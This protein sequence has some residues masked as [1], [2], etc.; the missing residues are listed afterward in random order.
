MPSFLDD[1]TSELCFDKEVFFNRDFS[2][3]EFVCERRKVVGLDQLRDDLRSH[4]KYLQACLVELIN[5]DYTD[6]V[7]L[8]SNLVG[9]E[10]YIGNISLPLNKLRD[11]VSEINNIIDGV[12]SETAK[13]LAERQKDRQLRGQILLAMEVH[14]GVQ[15]L[16]QEK[17]QI[18]TPD[19]VE[20]TANQIH[21][22]MISLDRCRNVA[23]AR[24]SEEVIDQIKFK[25]QS[26]LEA[27]FLEGL[28]AHDE[29]ILTHVLAVGVAIERVDYLEKFYSDRIVKSALEEIVTER[30]LREVLSEG[31]FNQVVMFVTTNCALLSKSA[32][33]EYN[34]ILNSV[35]PVFVSLAE[36]RVPTLFSLTSATMFHVRYNE[37]QR[38]LETLQHHMSEKS[39]LAFRSSESYKSFMSKWSVE[40]YF[41]LR[42]T[43]VA[44]NF[45]T[46]L[47]LENEPFGKKQKL[48]ITEN[49]FKQIGYCWS[50]GVY[51]EELKP[52]LFKLTLQLISRYSS[53]LSQFAARTHRVNEANAVTLFLCAAECLD[54]SPETICTYFETHLK[55]KEEREIIRGCLQQCEVQ[56]SDSSEKLASAA[57]VII[58]QLS[59]VGI[60]Q[61]SDIPRLYRRTNRELPGSAS[62]YVNNMFEPVMNCRKQSSQWKEKWSRVVAKEMCDSFL[63]TTRDVLDSVRKMEHSLRRL[64]KGKVA[65]TQGVTDDDKIRLQIMIDVEFFGKFLEELGSVPDS[66]GELFELAKGQMNGCQ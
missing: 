49:L 32:P 40:I 17:E 42:Y 22:L 43:E 53:Y 50:E 29:A 39:V 31:L 8:S 20:R 10:K 14:R 19:L 65:E 58:G 46:A 3:D 64:K 44:T 16:P 45:E 1:T 26:Y 12:L 25:L 28:Q 34:F 6:F 52:R 47:L 63:T 13:K 15:R 38:F 60:R 11:E 57:I 18:W 7:N 62:A 24:K 30:V 51:I 59:H 48:N 61:I 36:T 23:L 21:S 2:V 5:N 27:K 37:A 54:L 56:L 9:L 4:L 35:F 55:T 41:Q 66:Y 33:P